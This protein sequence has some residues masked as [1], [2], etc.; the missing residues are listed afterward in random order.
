MITYF[1]IRHDIG[2]TPL[3]KIQMISVQREINYY[4]YNS[5]DFT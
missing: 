3:G 4:F 5:P 2:H 1:K